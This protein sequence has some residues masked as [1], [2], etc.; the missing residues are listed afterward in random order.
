M[1]R[2]RVI[3][4]PPHR[5]RATQTFSYTGD[6]QTVEVPDGINAAT[7]TVLGAHGGSSSACGAG[8]DPIGGGDGGE[9]RG[10][11]GVRPR[12]VTFLSRLRAS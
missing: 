8:S 5:G 9:V 1:P 2:G 4:L 3:A 11:I 7:V 10:G 6:W 12:S